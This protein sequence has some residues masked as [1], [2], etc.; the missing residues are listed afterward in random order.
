V[1]IRTKIQNKGSSWHL[2]MKP[3]SIEKQTQ[4][5]SMSIHN[6]LTRLKLPRITGGSDLSF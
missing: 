6:L 2:Q 4:W 5:L 1:Q 3:S